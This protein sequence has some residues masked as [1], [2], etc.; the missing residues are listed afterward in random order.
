MLW[1][2]VPGYITAV[3]FGG[4]VLGI[5]IGAFMAMDN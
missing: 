1:E 5:I 4:V 3:F 2:W